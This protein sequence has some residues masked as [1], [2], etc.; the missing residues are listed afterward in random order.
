MTWEMLAKMQHAGVTIGSHT[1]THAWLTLEDRARALDELRGSRLALESRLGVSARHFAYPDGQFNTETA[2]LV[3]AAG[4]RYAYTTCLHRDPGHPLLTIPRRM[5]WQNA[6]L[7]RRG[8]F[9]PAVLSCQLQGVF[10]LM[11]GCEQKHAA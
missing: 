1:R 8:R 2:K 5:L 3:A 11:R 7:D 10:G 4:Y 6:C 9:S